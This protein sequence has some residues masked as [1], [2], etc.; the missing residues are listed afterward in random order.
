MRIREAAE[1][2]AGLLLE[3]VGELAAHHGQAAFVATD[4]ERLAAAI[5]TGR[6]AFL[7]AEANGDALGYLSWTR[8]YSIWSGG[9]Y[10]NVDDLFVRAVAR[11]RGVGRAL[12]AR[13]AAVAGAQGLR[14]RWELQADNH[15]AARFYE[16]LGAELQGKLIARWDGPAL[17]AAARG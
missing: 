14:A 7:I 9:D 10:L 17:A 12:M 13:F 11:D 8:A 2:D 15:D 16:R 3:L 1:G 4:A 6:A 5:V